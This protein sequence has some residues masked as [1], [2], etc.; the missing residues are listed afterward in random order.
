MYVRTRRE[1]EGSREESMEQGEGAAREQGEGVEKKGA[2]RE[3]GRVEQG[4][5]AEKEGAGKEQGEG[6]ESEQRRREQGGSREREG[7]G[8]REGGIGTNETHSIVAC[9]AGT[10]LCGACDPFSNI[11][12][13]H[14]LCSTETCGYPCSTC[15]PLLI[16]FLACLAFFL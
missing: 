2:G 13:S 5:G 3:Q 4:E 8:S 15:P 9:P 12:N 10:E 6:G 14:P 7:R 11:T 1:Q 16:F